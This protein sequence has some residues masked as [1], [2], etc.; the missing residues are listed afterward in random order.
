M[1]RQ[2]PGRRGV[3]Y[4]PASGGAL[5]T[6]VRDHT[7]LTGFPHEGFCD[8]QFYNLVNAAFPLPIDQW[9]SE[10]KPIVGG[11]RTTSEFLSK[12][13]NLSRVAYAVEGKSGG[14]KLLITT[15]RIRENFDETHPEVMALADAFLRYVT[16]AAFDPQETIPEVVLGG[17]L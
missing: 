15:L 4:F 5:G 3:E 2:T 11:I 6:I 10:V 7:A 13:K 8:L 1:L 14:G 17:L 16:G 9:P 12:T